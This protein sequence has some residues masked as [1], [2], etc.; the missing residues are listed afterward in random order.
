[1]T[2]E[3]CTSQELEEFINYIDPVDQDE[4]LEE[5]RAIESAQSM[6]DSELAQEKRNV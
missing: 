3:T 4:A 1:M 5:L 2:R 6:A